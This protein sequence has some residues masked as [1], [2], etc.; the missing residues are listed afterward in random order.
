MI[1]LHVS[2][3]LRH[4]TN[5]DAQLLEDL[6][7]QSPHDSLNDTLRNDRESKSSHADSC[8]TV[9][10]TLGE[11]SYETTDKVGITPGAKFKSQPRS[12]N[13]SLREPTRTGNKPQNV[14]STC[15]VPS[16]HGK[17]RPRTSMNEANTIHTDTE[18]ASDAKCCAGQDSAVYDE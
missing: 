9:L 14:P 1:P 17:E 15:S 12:C 6:D 4:L 18:N 3:L 16:M 5:L 13:S 11:Q 8:A 2:M 10:Q 7:E